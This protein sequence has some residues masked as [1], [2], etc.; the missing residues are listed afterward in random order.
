MGD[1][2]NLKLKTSVEKCVCLFTNGQNKK[3]VEIT[4]SLPRRSG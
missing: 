1:F 4:E 2:L 3:K